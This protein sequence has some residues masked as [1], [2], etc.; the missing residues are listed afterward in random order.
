[1]TRL[2]RCLKRH[3][4]INDLPKL[5]RAGKPPISLISQAIDSE[6]RK[7]A[8]VTPASLLWHS[9][10]PICHAPLYNISHRRHRQ[11][12]PKTRQKIASA[13]HAR[14]RLT[15]Y[16]PNSA[17]R[18]ANGGRH[19]TAPTWKTRASSQRSGVAAGRKTSTDLCMT[20]CGLPEASSALPSHI[21]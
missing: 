11:R 3:P 8:T 15:C 13:L 1:M 17:I 14:P 18:G 19:D 4:T 6:L 21:L 12:T 2:I 7:T 9:S 10:P 20:R 5:C 16:T